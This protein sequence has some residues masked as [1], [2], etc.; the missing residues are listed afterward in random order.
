MVPR[1]CSVGNE[2]RVTLI[3]VNEA[4][5]AQPFASRHLA[6]APL[7]FNRVL[8]TFTGVIVINFRGSSPSY[9]NFEHLRVGLNQWNAILEASAQGWL[10]SHTPLPSGHGYLIDVR[11][12]DVAPFVTIN[13]IFNNDG[14]DNDGKAVDAV[15]VTAQQNRLTMPGNFRLL[16]FD[17]W[18]AVRDSDA[19]LYRVGYQVTAVA[20]VYTAAMPM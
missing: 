10:A 8:C 15:S 7:A 3:T 5:N 1:G 9:W 19:Y 17:A 18:L 20:R 13:S 16:T 12:E 2:R 4:T 6:V 11:N 14:A